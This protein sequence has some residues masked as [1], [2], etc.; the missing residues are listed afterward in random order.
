MLNNL[1]FTLVHRSSGPVLAMVAAIAIGVT[2]LPRAVAEP[3]GSTDQLVHSLGSIE[4]FSADF[5][6]ARINSR[7][8]VARESTGEFAIAR[9][10]RFHW[11]Y[12]KPHVQELT[13]REGTLWVYEPDL[14]QVTRSPLDSGTAAPIGILMGDRPLE[15]V[16]RIRELERSEGD[17]Q[18]FALEPREDSGD[19]REVLLGLDDAGLKEMRFIDQLDQSTRVIFSGREFNE[20]VDE[21]RFHFE[22]PDGVDV[23][24]ARK[25]PRMQ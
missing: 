7:G 21:D 15:E 23:V 24:E 18:W 11:R 3:P 14:M 2:H 19:F 22:V 10:D 6:Q 8:D 17:L 12:E 9:P 5:E 4:T 1:F 25:P 20:P 16:F 13:A